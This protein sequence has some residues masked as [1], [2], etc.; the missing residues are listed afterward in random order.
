[1]LRD[2]KAKAAAAAATGLV[3]C[4]VVDTEDEEDERDSEIWLDHSIPWDSC[5]A[6][7]DHTAKRDQVGICGQEGG[8][9]IASP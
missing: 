4:R 9:G 7:V 2:D 8:G 6:T 5:D 1:M 3:R